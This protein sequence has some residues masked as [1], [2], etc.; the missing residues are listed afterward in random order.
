MS[1]DAEMSDGAGGDQVLVAEFVLGLL[2]ADEHA[3]V[4]ARI[5]AEPDLARE[6]ALWQTRL[7]SLDREFVE[8]SPPPR[9]LAALEARLFGAAAAGVKPGF[10]NNLLVW[11]GLAA[12]CLAVAVVAV[13][14]SVLV[15][16]APIGGPQLMATLEQQGS[17][18][19]F[20][21][22]YNAS[23]DTL[24][25]AALA[26]QPVPQKDYELWAIKGDN[27]PQS[28]GVVPVN[29][30]T[31]ITLPA[32]IKEGFGPGTVLAVTLEPK[33][34]SPTGKPT[35]PIVAKGAAIAI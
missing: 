31:D 33:G 11:R 1:M 29:A 2:D 8:T 32:S 18:V 10:W 15:P 7:S 30:T 9:V 21:A 20:V 14:F 24:K 22:L 13:G 35:G 23:T 28:M 5:A 17:A 19:K 6:L 3:R 16:R 25:L 4:A 34:G 27:A 26:G 12:A